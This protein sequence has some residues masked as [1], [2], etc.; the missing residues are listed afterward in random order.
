MKTQINPGSSALFVEPIY[1]D[2]KT[3]RGRIHSLGKTA[4][5]IY[6]LEQVVYY[7]IDDI[8]STHLIPNK[9]HSVFY[10]KISAVEETIKEVKSEWASAF[11]WSDDEHEDLMDQIY[12][13]CPRD[14]DPPGYKD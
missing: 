14:E 1:Q 3:V 9:I 7:N 2:E 6:R 8:L 13:G 5:S 12:C 10:Y 4:E 11:N